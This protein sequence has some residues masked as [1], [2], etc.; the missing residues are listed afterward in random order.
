MAL[1]AGKHYPGSSAEMMAWL[2]TDAA[3]SDY[4][5]WL[6]WRDGFECPHCGSAQSWT[7]PDG[8]RSCVRYGGHYLPPHE[9]A[10]HYLVRRCLVD[11]HAE[12][13][14]IRPGFAKSSR[15]QFLRHCVDDASPTLNCDGA[16]TA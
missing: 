5:D 15:S 16:A 10:S 7:L 12:G 9:N 3:C 6:R 4:L 14:S 1:T 2:P 11:D 13:R 8:R